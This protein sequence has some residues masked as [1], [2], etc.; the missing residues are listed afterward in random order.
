MLSCRGGGGGVKLSRPV[1]LAPLPPGYQSKIVMPI[2]LIL[3][4][5]IVK[6][7]Q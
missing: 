3:N 1:C 4:Y 5:L 7:Y 6:M 2:L